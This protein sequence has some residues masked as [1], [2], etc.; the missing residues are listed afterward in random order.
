MPAHSS[1]IPLPALQATVGVALGAIRQ[2]QGKKP[3]IYFLQ[4]R[5][6][7][8]SLCPFLHDEVSE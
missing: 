6:A 4:G 7:K 8:G 3:C 1:T 5:C 2:E